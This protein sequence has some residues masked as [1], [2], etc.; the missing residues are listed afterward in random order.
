MLA[1]L[2][3]MFRRN[4]RN[5]AMEIQYQMILCVEPR[6]EQDSISQRALYHTCSADCLLSYEARKKT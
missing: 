5:R 4:K 2:N 1:M 6:H 3:A